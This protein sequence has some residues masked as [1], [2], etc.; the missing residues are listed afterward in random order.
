MAA[1][2]VRAGGVVTRIDPAVELTPEALAEIQAA[3]LHGYNL[4]SLTHRLRFTWGLELPN[5]VNAQQPFRHVVGDLIAYA[6]S[7]GRV[8]DLLAVTYSA[9]PQNP[10]LS[11]AA[12]K[13]LGDPQAAL[14]KYEG[15]APP[16][17]TSL[18]AL[19]T[20]RSRL[21]SFAEF[22]ARVN[23]IGARL[24]RIEVPDGGGT[25]WL[26]GASHVLTNYHVVERV[27]SGEVSP[28]QLVCRFDFWSESE[29]D[30]TGTPVRLAPEWLRA[31]SRYSQSDLTATGQPAPDELDYALLRL[32]EPAGA[33]DRGGATRGWF[34]FGPQAPIVARADPAMIPQHPDG[35][36]LEVAFGRVLEF[37]GTGMRYR[38]DVT[39]EPG[40]SGS[41][42]LNADLTLFGLHHAADPGSRPA[43]N[44]AVPLWRIARDLQARNV[45]WTG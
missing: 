38:Y 3:I 6:V 28:E 35:R 16:L 36:E 21:F 5:E 37:P 26:V 1:I 12:N 24:C 8:A 14:A 19:V 43:Y 13:Y 17:P 32:A 11:Q 45:D 25:G 9:K 41:P 10:K 23:A 20:T 4:V 2:A 22:R 34:E 18:E 33:Q 39:T 15:A 29:A 27:V 7:E 42:V 44:Q 31:S 30:P 40:S